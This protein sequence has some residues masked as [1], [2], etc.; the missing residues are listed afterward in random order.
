MM[1][2]A[3]IVQVSC[4]PVILSSGVAKKAHT[5]QF[6]RETTPHGKQIYAT[7]AM[8]YAEPVLV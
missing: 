5:E 6:L 8:K 1:K 4:H 7:I 3:K 2:P